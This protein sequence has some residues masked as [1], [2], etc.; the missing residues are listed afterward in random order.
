M[1]TWF[2]SISYTAVPGRLKENDAISGSDRLQCCRP[3]Q[4][5]IKIG[6]F[7]SMYVRK[8]R[9]I[10]ATAVWSV[11]ETIGKK[12]IVTK[13]QRVFPAYIP[14]CG[15][16]LWMWAHVAFLWWSRF[17]CW[18]FFYRHNSSGPYVFILVRIHGC[19]T[20][21]RFFNAVSSIAADHCH[22]QRRFIFTNSQAQ[23]QRRFC[24]TAQTWRSICRWP[25]LR[26]GMI[27]EL[28]FKW[29]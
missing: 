19:K 24:R 11:K 23:S 7:T 8:S 2:Y 4:N 3:R 17:L 18:P 14:G 10:C 16:T 9:N 26:T 5:K 25:L 6:S 22:W 12:T 27:L 15:G 29:H 13:M 21:D 1:C 28:S 20:A